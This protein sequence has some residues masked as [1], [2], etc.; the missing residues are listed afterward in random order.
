MAVRPPAEEAQEAVPAGAARAI[1]GQAPCRHVGRRIP[2]AD[3]GPGRG[4]DTGALPGF[5]AFDWVVPGVILTGPGLLL[6]ALIAAQMV[7]AMAWLP[8]VRRKI[9]AFGLS[10][11]RAPPARLDASAGHA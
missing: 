1:P 3:P 5:E 4:F 10:R 9:G 8:I 11:R 6:L 2:A 7:G